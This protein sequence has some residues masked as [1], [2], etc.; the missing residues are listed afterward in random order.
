MPS[1]RTDES[2]CQGGSR[3]MQIS[4]LNM[5]KERMENPNALL[6]FSVYHQFT[7]LAMKQQKIAYS[8]TLCK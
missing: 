3:E 1:P 7:A 6:S 8:L 5:R 4:R 2:D